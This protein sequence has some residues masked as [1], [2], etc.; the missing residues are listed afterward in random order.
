MGEIGY[1]VNS[2][3]GNAK[4]CVG[5]SCD[6]EFHASTPE[7]AKARF[8]EDTLSQ[9]T[10]D[11]LR[12]FLTPFVRNPAIEDTFPD[13]VLRLLY[14]FLST[15]PYRVVA[16]VPSGSLAY[17]TNMN[18]VPKD[19]DFVVL[20]EPHED[21]EKYRRAQVGEVDLFLVPFNLIEPYT[22]HQSQVPE[23]YFAA[24]NGDFLIRDDA[25]WQDFCGEQGSA[26]EFRSRLESM[27]R[28]R[29]E[30]H[31]AKHRSGE[32][33]EERQVREYKHF[34]RWEL[35]LRRLDEGSDVPF[36]PFT[37]R[38]SAA[39]REMYLKSMETAPG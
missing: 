23:G 26:E 18:P 16:V 1:H 28:E 39:E 10:H 37:P 33:N 27:Y 13:E 22:Q 30:S 24:A 34:R 20:L 8:R 31:V 11:A 36:T 5:K 38:L 19:Y 12:D 7:A 2:V 15:Y 6:V 9:G 35:Y 25:A 3:T 21:H 17:N 29:V 32:Y 4:K 14:G